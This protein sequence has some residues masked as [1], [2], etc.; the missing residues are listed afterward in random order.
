M[1]CRRL[2]RPRPHPALL[3][4]GT[5]REL[6][7]Q[8][9]AQGSTQR[10]PFLPSPPTPFSLSQFFVQDGR[11]FH[12][13]AMPWSMECIFFFC[14]LGRALLKSPKKKKESAC[15]SVFILGYCQ[16]LIAFWKDRWGAR[17]G[18][19]SLVPFCK[20]GLSFCFP[21]CPCRVFLEAHGLLSLQ[22]RLWTVRAQLFQRT[23]FL[24]ATSGLSCPV[25]R[26][27]LVSQTRD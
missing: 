13:S 18:C 11:G 8:A 14:S 16:G 4:E 17:A 6:P 5:R 27:I 3:G 1:Q 20:P 15:K 12:W 2:P 10:H 24:V 23:G 22:S 9:L 25:T 7:A 26:G 19:P 21:F